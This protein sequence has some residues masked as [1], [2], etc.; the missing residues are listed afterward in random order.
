[1]N[2]TFDLVF[3]GGGAKGMVFVGALEEFEKAGHTYDRLLGTSA[4]AIVATLLAAGY[5]TQEMLTALGEQENGR[6]IFESFMGWP[7]EF[8]DEAIHRSATLALLQKIDI[9]VLPNAIEG[10]VDF[11]LAKILM[12]TAC[13]LFSFIERGGWFSADKFLEWLKRKLDEGTFQ[14][15]PRN[16]SEMTLKELYAVTGRDFSLVTSNI[17]AERMLVLNHHTTPDLPVVWAVRMSM[18]IPLIWPEVEWQFGWGTYLGK[19]ISSHLMVDGGLLS[20]F[21]IELFVS[22]EPHI[23]TIMGEKKNIPVLGL[24]IDETIDVPGAPALTVSSTSV[25]DFSQLQ[26]VQR[27]NRLIN[28]ATGA[29]DKMVIEAFERKV[30]RL[31]AKGYGTTEFDMSDERREALI[32]AGRASMRKFLPEY[33]AYLEEL[34]FG[35]EEEISYE[36]DVANYVDEVATKILTW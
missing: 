22:A 24:L 12:Q 4:G 35:V 8:E 20:N 19:D 34:P 28:T 15:K 7:S 13:H 9:P 14:G 31:P 33:L 18:G 5:T 3:E 17:T 23:T 2:L 25:F 10:P 29:H 1:M 11:W 21:P 27:L 6:P 36:L 26:L 16:F 30:V 32:T